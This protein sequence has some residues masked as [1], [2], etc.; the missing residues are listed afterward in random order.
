MCTGNL[1]IARAQR[2]RSFR[3][4]K[5]TNVK[6]MANE[7]IKIS[8]RRIR[9]AVPSRGELPQELSWAN[10]QPTR[11]RE[12]QDVLFQE[13]ILLPYHKIYRGVRD[14]RDALQACYTDRGIRLDASFLLGFRTLETL[15]MHRIAVNSSIRHVH[16]S[17]RRILACPASIS[18]T[19]TTSRSEKK[20][21]FSAIAFSRSRRS[22]PRANEY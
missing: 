16:F 9:L 5:A 20:Q 12:Y 22:R 15:S 14:A 10:K 11:S 21:I 6:R 19:R 17:D 8:A 3:A 13:I 7:N 18:P 1:P 2:L 4:G